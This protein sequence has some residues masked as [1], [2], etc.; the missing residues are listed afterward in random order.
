[1]AHPILGTLSDEVTQSK[2]VMR[3]AT[4]L[5]DGFAAKLQAGIEAALAAGATKEELDGL[6]GL[7]AEL[8]AERV[9][10]ARAVAANP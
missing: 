5:I 2:G 3:S 7:E 9:E 6:I 4:L 1:M 10:L 8:E